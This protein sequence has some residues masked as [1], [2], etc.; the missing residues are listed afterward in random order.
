MFRI[1]IRHAIHKRRPY[2]G[3]SMTEGP[4]KRALSFKVMMLILLSAMA[5]A[6]GIAYLLV[7]PFFHPHAH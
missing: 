3:E 4:R 2:Y 5:I 7:Y 6:A 1:E